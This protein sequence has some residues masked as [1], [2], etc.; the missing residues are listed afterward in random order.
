MPLPK[1]TTAE[2]VWTD[3]KTR[4]VLQRNEFGRGDKEFAVLVETAEETDAFG[5]PVWDRATL[6]NIQ[7]ETK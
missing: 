3:G 2:Q 6:L 4:V 7:K 1:G 5:Q